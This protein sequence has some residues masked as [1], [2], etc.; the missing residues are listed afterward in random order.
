MRTVT[1]KRRRRARGVVAAGDAVCPRP[2]LYAG[3]ADEIRRRIA[4]GHYAS[5]SAIPSEAELVREFG[6]SA[7]T[8]RRAIRE[9]TFEG[10]VYG[11]QGRGVFVANRQRVIR[12]LRGDAS[13]SIGDEIRRAGLEPG[14]KELA[15]EPVTDAVAASRL[16][17]RRQAP[18]IR[19]EKLVLAGGEPV[20]IDTVYLPTALAGRLRLELGG[21]FTF[22]LL[23][24]HG[25]AVDRTE[26]QFEGGA[27]SEEHA[28]LLGLPPR[29]PLIL[30]RY[31]LFTRA[32]AP[33]L[34]GVTTA[35]SD[36][37]IFAL[38]LAAEPPARPRGGSPRPRRRLR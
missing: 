13:T 8:V 29:S 28:A 22:S 1:G 20:S 11:R 36:R 9:L 35:R 32:G 5:A 27:V 37:F 10:V 31:T 34:T 16:G 24:R 4:A 3:V 15:C 7:I 26:F 12:V 33:I 19:H 14:L 23:A 6:V 38:S 2:F 25:I 17:L 21:E 30:V 18:I